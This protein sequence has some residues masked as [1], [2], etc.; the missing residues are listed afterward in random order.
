MN[1]DGVR[2]LSQEVILQDPTFAFISIMALIFFIIAWVAIS[3]DNGFGGWS[4]VVLVFAIIAL[5]VLLIMAAI[6]AFEY[7]TGRSTYKCI[8]EDNVSIQ[9]IYENYNVIGQDGEI[10]I[11][12][13]RKC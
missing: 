13:D 12:E 11:L 9:E 6:G 8:F 4:L 5:I 1:I 2:V 3:I 10:W 7:D